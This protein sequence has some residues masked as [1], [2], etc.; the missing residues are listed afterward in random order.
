MTSFLTSL[1]L[2]LIFPTPSTEPAVMFVGQDQIVIPDLTACCPF[3]LK[4]NPLYEASGLSVE[5]R[6]W[7]SEGDPAT[8]DEKCAEY[9]SLKPALLAAMVYPDADGPRL[10]VCI[11]FFAWTFLLDNI[12]DD[13]DNKENRIVGEIIM[14]SFHHPYTV[15]SSSRIAVLASEW[16]LIWEILY[17]YYLGP[18]LSSGL[19]SGSMPLLKMDVAAASWRLLRSLFAVSTN[20]PATVL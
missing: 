1:S 16:V 10:R 7:Y 2:H 20:K 11:D 3:P 12:T 19:S 6:E 9:D 14:N 15:E 5:C 17:V 4:V 13:M 18:F 8:M